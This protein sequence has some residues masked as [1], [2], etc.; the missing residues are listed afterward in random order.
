MIKLFESTEFM[1][2]L[3]LGSFFIG[4]WIFIKTRIALL[5]PVVIAI[6]IIIAFLKITG[7]K[8]EVFEVQ[9]SFINF[10]L[11]PTVVALGYLLYEQIH[12]LKQNTNSILIAVFTGSLVG[13]IS[14]I[15]IAHFM[16]GDQML[17]YSISSKSVT[18]PIAMSLSS[19]AG[20]NISLTAIVV[21][22]CGIYGSIVGPF[23]MKF[24][25]IE[26]RIATGLALGASSHGI[27][28][29]RAMEMGMTEG[30][31]SG[32][33]I[34]LMGVMTALQIPLFHYLYDLIK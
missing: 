1:L 16:G 20:G 28:T 11:G 8:Y 13:I 9:T 23:I 27:G 14:V 31:I 3:L 24:L 15:A 21:V 30:A 2:L 7:V 34:G 4:R 12:L 6:A 17:I 29:A 5:H 18:T 22:L 33:A 10:L 19:H 32:L 26:S 25:K